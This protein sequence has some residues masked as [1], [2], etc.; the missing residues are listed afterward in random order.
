MSRLKKADT[1]QN[2]IKAEGGGGKSGND[3]KTGQRREGKRWGWVGA[4]RGGKNNKMV[5]YELNRST[6]YGHEFSMKI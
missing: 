4:G 6:I 3:N 5:E 2:L 1:K